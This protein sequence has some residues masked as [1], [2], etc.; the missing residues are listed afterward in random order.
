MQTTKQRYLDYIQYILYKIA[1]Q[2]ISTHGRRHIFLQRGQNTIVTAISFSK[3]LQ[4][5]DKE[6]KNM[7]NFHRSF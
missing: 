2:L 4:N 1:L 6:I 5:P 7:G 3:R